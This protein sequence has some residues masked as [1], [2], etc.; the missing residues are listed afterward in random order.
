MLRVEDVD[1]S[2]SQA[3]A[4]GARIVHAPETYMYGE[5]QA[6]LED[7]AGHQWTLTQTIED[8]DPATWG[9]EPVDLDPGA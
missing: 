3:L 8:V 6:T 9:G 2:F 1:A 4:H 5:R 7:F